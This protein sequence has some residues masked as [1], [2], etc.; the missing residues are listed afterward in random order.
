[1]TAGTTKVWVAPLAIAP[2]R[3]AGVLAQQDRARAT[4]NANL[5]IAGAAHVKQRHRDQADGIWPHRHGTAAHRTVRV[6][7]AV[8]ELSALGP[9]GGAR[10]VHHEAD[11]VRV[12]A[13]PS[14]RCPAARNGSYSSS[15]PMTTRRGT[16][17]PALAA[18]ATS[19]NCVPMEE[20]HRAGVLKDVADLVG[21][22]PEVDGYRGG[23]E[24]GRSQCELDRGEVV[25]VED[26]QPVAASH[27]GI[28]QRAG[29]AED[30]LAPL[31]PGEG[32]RTE[33]HRGVIGSHVGPVIHSVAQQD[34]AGAEEK[35]HR[36]PFLGM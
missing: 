11:V 10:G 27:P 22:Q 12:H 14:S 4:M 21:T 19:V 24:R 32:L 33:R 1:M 20:D 3:A 31:S 26:C 17:V 15:P 5:G 2:K 6:D 18:L 25:E 30:S 36:E 29:Q 28:A 16:R 7:A 8:G 23:T 35:R 13:P 9:A 34:G